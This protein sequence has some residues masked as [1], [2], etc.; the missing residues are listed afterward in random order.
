MKTFNKLSILFLAAPVII[1]PL[2]V[3][4]CEKKNI[5]APPLPKPVEDE[6][7]LD[8]V[9]PDKDFSYEEKE[10]GDKKILQQI[11]SYNRNLWEHFEK[12]KDMDFDD[13]LKPKDITNINNSLTKTLKTIRKYSKMSNHPNSYDNLMSNDAWVS[14]EYPNLPIQFQDEDKNSYEKFINSKQWRKPDN[15]GNG[16]DVDSKEFKNLVQRFNNLDTTLTK[17][18]LIKLH[19]YLHEVGIR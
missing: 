16:I 12:M 18:D 8:A 4:A 6:E 11:H 14:V 5:I 10:E 13:N 2:S 7:D 9:I 19:T 17:M 3:V 15:I 1:A